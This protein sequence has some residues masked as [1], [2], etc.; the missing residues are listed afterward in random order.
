MTA[1]IA[2]LDLVPSW[3]YAIVVAVLLAVLGAQAVHVAALK[4]QVVDARSTLQRERMLAAQAQA[5]AERH[6]RE[7]EQ[8]LVAQT[9]RIAREHDQRAS[10]AAARAAR[11][12]RAAVGLR[13]QIDRLA[14][15]AVPSDPVAAAADHEAR[16][17]RELL[18]ACA[19]EYR[20]V[21]A[22]ADGLRDAVAALQEWAHAV[23]KGQK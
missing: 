11:A 8:E 16:V 23:V 1:V 17:A 21:A 22:E 3:V 4:S 13:E 20:G 15:R 14:S 7:R 5:D 10:L 9:E 19:D 6:A 12:E 18:A 2:L